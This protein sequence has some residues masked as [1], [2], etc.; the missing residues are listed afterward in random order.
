M[1]AGW[2]LGGAAEVAL[3]WWCPNEEY[4]ALGALELTVVCEGKGPGAA[5]PAYQHCHGQEQGSLRMLHSKD[6]K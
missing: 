5:G 6:C 1:L 4:A 3:S 2:I